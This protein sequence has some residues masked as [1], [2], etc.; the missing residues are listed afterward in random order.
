MAK[1]KAPKAKSSKGKIKDAARKSA[2]KTKGDLPRKPKKPLSPAVKAAVERAIARAEGKPIPG[3]EHPSSIPMSA[4]SKA[5]LDP[6]I[7]KAAS[8]GSVGEPETE[9]KS[10]GERAASKAGRKSDYRPEFAMAAGEMCLNG[11]TDQDLADEF[12]VSYRTIMR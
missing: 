5:M 7:V 12:G 9:T 4:K 10:E 8:L 1:P 2:K 6:V 11:A 3:P